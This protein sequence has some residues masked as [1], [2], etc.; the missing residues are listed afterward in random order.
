MLPNGSLRTVEVRLTDQAEV[1]RF[2]GELSKR[3]SLA[4]FAGCALMIA[5]TVLLFS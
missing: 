3:F 4:M 1:E 5:G 2:G